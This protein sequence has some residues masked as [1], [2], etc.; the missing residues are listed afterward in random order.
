MKKVY[1]VSV[2]VVTKRT[3][4][5]ELEQH[6]VA[7]RSVS[8]K[9]AEQAAKRRFK[10]YDVWNY[11]VETDHYGAPVASET[12]DDL[13]AEIQRRIASY[14]KSITKTENLSDAEISKLGRVD[15]MRKLLDYHALEIAKKKLAA[16]D[17][18]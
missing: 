1:L 13:K 9:G 15:C 2:C 7:V 10:G 18:L 14:N 11:C 4:P 8:R 17:A 6:F 5:I 3:R 16:L 12:V